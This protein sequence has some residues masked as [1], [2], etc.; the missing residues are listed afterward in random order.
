[1]IWDVIISIAILLL[2]F[3]LVMYVVGK[4]R[5]RILAWG[6]DTYVRWYPNPGIGIQVGGKV[7][8]VSLVGGYEVYV[9]HPLTG[10]WV[11][12]YSRFNRRRYY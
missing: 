12:V 10:E 4:L 2:L 3:P 9:R 5:R 1:M 11:V 7:Y 8:S 6:K